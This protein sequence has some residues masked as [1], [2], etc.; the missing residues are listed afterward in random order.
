MIS[1]TIPRISPEADEP[2]GSSAASKPAIDSTFEMP[3]KL[4]REFGSFGWVCP[5]C[6]SVY[7]P[8]AIECFRCNRRWEV[9]VN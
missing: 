6:G 8:L 9:E 5:R 2:S 4:E 3:P 1:Q 7:S